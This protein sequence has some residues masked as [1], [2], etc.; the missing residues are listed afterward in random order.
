[1]SQK[2]ALITGI[3]GQDGVFLSERLIQTGYQVIGLSR[4]AHH[5]PA[6]KPSN[7]E[8]IKVFQT[9]YS[10]NHLNSI[11]KK[12]QP[13]EVYHLAAQPYVSK[14]WVMIDETIQGTVQTISH[15][16]EICRDYP[17]IRFFHASSSEIYADTNHAID[18]N[19]QKDPTTP[20]GCAKLY[21][22]QLV[23]AFR[24]NYG[25]FAVNG[26][27]F[28]HESELRHPDFF[29]QKIICGALDIVSGK[30]EVLKLGNLN[31]IRDWGSAREY[32]HVIPSLL[33]QPQ[34]IDV[35]ICSGMGVSA[36]ELA[37]TVF[38]SVGL[39]PKKHIEIDQNLVRNKEKQS[40]VGS[41]KKIKSITSW[42]PQETIQTVLMQMM[43]FEIKKRGIH[44][45]RK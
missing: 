15:L 5:H 40:I 24:E 23:K 37:T 29:S 26:I 32:M 20:Y 41:N 10:Q 1:M 3:S 28:N 22:H 45:P 12:H 39:D 2:T 42:S 43:T 31:V 19:T 16:L 30:K 27:L 14:S 18:E 13:Q 36:L 25:L 4:S 44:D 34:P 6:F 8:Q 9:D 17:K 21:A 35:N 33:E 7:P 11:F 38:E